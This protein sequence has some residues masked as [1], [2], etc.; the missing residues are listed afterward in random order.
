VAAWF[1]ELWAVDRLAPAQVIEGLHSDGLEFDRRTG[2]GVVLHML[3]GLAV[4]GRFGMTA[5][6]GSPHEANHL[7]AA[8]RPAVDRL[9]STWAANAAAM[10]AA[11]TAE[12]V[13]VPRQRPGPGAGSRKEL[14]RS[15]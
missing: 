14:T 5:V 1:Q 10:P 8:V 4:D 15:G 2:T 11:S 3:S 13:R 6:G 9:C 7:Y 12:L